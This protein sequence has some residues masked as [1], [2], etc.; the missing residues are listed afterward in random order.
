MR[1]YS[2]HQKARLS[3]AAAIDQLRHLL[4]RSADGAV[5]YRL[6]LSELEDRVL[7]SASPAAVMVES[8]PAIELAETAS[9][10]VNGSNSLIQTA[11]VT[12]DATQAAPESGSSLE[13]NSQFLELDGTT[14]SSSSDSGQGSDTISQ[15]SSRTAEQ[16][17]TEVVFIDE[18][19]QNFEQLVADL[20]AQR[21]AGRAVDF[22][23]LD[24]QQDGIDQISE[25]LQRYS[26]LD[27]IHFVSHGTT[28][29]VKLGATWLRIGSLDGYAGTIAGWGSAFGTDG[30]LLIYGCDL[31]AD[32][33][34]Q[35]LV[36]SI[37]ALTGADVAAST[38]DTGSALFGGDWELEY[39]IGT[40]EADVAFTEQLQTEWDGLLAAPT[41]VSSGEFRING[42]TTD[43]QL[44]IAEDRGS[45]Q[46]VS[47][48]ADGSYVVV[49]SSLN[50]DGSGQGVYARR[51][52][53]AGAAL[54]TEFRVNQT[55]TNDQQWARVASAVDGSFVVTWTSNQ[56]A[57]G[58]DVYFRRFAAN[59]TALTAEARANTTLSGTQNNSVVG[60]N[61]TSGEFI[62]AWQG[63]GS[64]TGEIDGAGV[65]AQ[66][67]SNSGAA[68]GGEFRVN[69]N[70]ANTQYDVAISVN[71]NGSF[72]VAWDDSA[73]TH[74]QRFGNTGN[75]LGG[76]VTV[77]GSVSAGNAAVA[78][79]SDG[80]LIVTWRASVLDQGVYLR[81]YDASGTPL[82]PAFIANT[83]IIGSQTNPSIAMDSS[84]NFIIVWEG[85]GTGDNSGVFARR[86][87]ANSTAQGT[88]FRI[89]QT[90]TGTQQYA[91][92]AMADLDNYVVVW[93]GNG[94]QTGQVDSSG[95]FARQYGTGTVPT[96]ELWFTTGGNGA[97][98]GSTWT[99]AEVLQFG[100][101]GDTFDVNAGT[102]SGTISKLPG[103]VA[104]Y[105]IRAMHYVEST[106][107]LGTTGT[108][109][110]VL[111]GDLILTLDPGKD[112]T[113][114]AGGVAVD[115]MDIVVFRPTV[116][117]DYSSGTYSMLIDGDAA[118][119]DSGVHDAIKAYNVHAISLVEKDTLVGGTVLTKGTFLVAHSDKSLHHNIYTFNVVGTGV[120]AATE[121]TPVNL[122]LSGQSLGLDGQPSDPWKIQGLHLLQQPTQFNGTTL[123]SGTLLVTVEGADIYGGQAQ[124]EFDIVALTVTKT[125]QDAV[126]GTVASGQLFFDGS[127]IAINTPTDELLNGFTIISSSFAGAESNLAPT[128]N[129]GGAYVTTEGSAVNLIGSAS[130]DPD[131]DPLTYAWDLDND[132]YFGEVGEPTTVSP[133]VSWATLQ[134][135]GINDDTGGPYTIALRVDDG[136]GGVHTAT[137]TVIVNNAAP[138]LSTTGSG[139][140]TAGSSYTLNLSASDPGADTISSW[141]INWGDGSIETIAGN[142]TSATH[143]YNAA[144]FTYNILASA[145]DE[146][147][148]YLQNELLV[149][150][151]KNDRVLRYGPDAGFLQAFAT[152]DGSDYPVDTIIGPDGKL[153]VSG[154]NSDN[155]LRYDAM[156]GAFIDAFVPA[157]SGGLDSAAG[158][159]FGP[160]GHLY[161]ASRLTSEVLRFN[162]S[163]GVF[164]DAFVTAG[165]GGLDEVEGL[166]F[167]PDGDLYVTDYKNNAV[168]KYDGT[169]GAFDSVFV[170][171]GSGGL[172]K[173]ED[174]TF[175]PDGNLYVADDSGSSV[176]RYDGTTGTFINTFVASGSGGLT[177]ATGV[178][179]GPDGNLYV[180]SWG[181]DSVLRYDGIT[182]AFIDAYISSGSGGLDE[183]DYFTFIPE[184]QVSVTAIP[185]SSPT[186]DAG[187]PYIV[188]EGTTVSLDGTASSDSDGMLTLYEWDLN[189]DGVTFNSTTTGS[190]PVFNAATIDGPGSRA[191]ALRVTDNQGAVSSLSTTTVT[192]NN[193]APTATPDSGAGFTTDENTS[194]TTNSVLANDSDVP[195]DTLSVTGLGTAGTVGLVINNGDGTFSYNPNGQFESLAVGQQ[196]T[197]SFSYTVSDGDGG[198]SLATVTV[199]INGAN[200]VPVVTP[201]QTFNISESATNGTSLG[202]VAATD[203]DAG[204]T[205]SN[206]QITGGNAA[207]VFGI[208][209]STGA[210]TVVDRSNLNFESNTSYVL[211]VT[212]RDGVNTSSVE[213]IAISVLD[214]NDETPVITPGQTFNVSESAANGTPLGNVAATDADAGTTLSNWQI[215]GGNAAGVFGINASTGQLTVADNS[216][217]NFEILSTYTL[218]VRTQDGAG[219]TGSGIVFV[220][221]SNTNETPTTSGLSDVVVNEDSADVLI[222]L[223][224]AFSDPET[225]SPGLSYSITSNSNPAIFSGTPI[226]GGNLILKFAANANGN[227]TVTVS[228]TDPQGLFATASFTVTVLPVADA[229]ISNADSYL[230]TSDRLTVP[231]GAGV[232]ANDSDPDGDPLTALL[233]TGPTHGSL[234]L[235]SNGG[236]SFIPDAD[237]RGIDTFVYQP[238]DGASTGL[239]RTVILNVIRVIA[240]PPAPSVDTSQVVETLTSEVTAESE[241]LTVSVNAPVAVTE[242]V[243]PTSAIDDSTTATTS[244]NAD[245]DE[246]TEEELAAGFVADV[247]VS[248]FFSVDSDRLELRDATSVRIFTEE[249][250]R[251]V[252]VSTESENNFR[253]SLRFDGEDLSYLVGAEFIQELEQVEDGFE[254]DGAVPE[255]ATGTAVATTASL[256]VGYIMWMLRGGYVL[257]SVL[258]T[259][260]VWQNIDPLPVL[261][262]LEAVDDD[263]DE[264]LET[265]ID[266]A[267]D[268]ADHSENQVADEAAADA[269]LKDELV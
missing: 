180:G 245:S 196:T 30:D 190:T 247:T 195:G 172:N 146:D 55:T 252:T 26:N 52:D 201:G 68:L 150:S 132:G 175:G 248:D 22:F 221:V 18:A 183:T 130:S 137:T 73:G 122:L 70:T 199:T 44:T 82:A 214:Q 116:T 7:L 246:E 206:W 93:S 228:A 161:V 244:S 231:P 99:D 106:V 35:M 120:G 43:Q 147:G 10:L 77:D 36:D 191:V 217:L 230:V 207:G 40:V 227:A 97:G 250:D 84:G 45:Q 1:L 129:A 165:S 185:N 255:W 135:F 80:S 168:Y 20:Q 209:A 235:L 105:D 107:T 154:W 170:S 4:A 259:M 265:M 202:N 193:V 123:L 264:S 41:L 159:A 119:L 118:D 131:S 225:P 188:N 114:N 16:I 33:R 266:R 242:Y 212:V 112:T 88:E 232:L 167:G 15:A 145:T 3:A 39:S 67:F 85:E 63:N 171:A 9:P 60:M 69:A 189:Y 186:A 224:T 50:Q 215:T 65:F 155:V 182:G 81:R 249:F 51:F 153:Y 152:S 254:F 47:L 177:F 267:S 219:N 269:A 200:D 142:P 6:D 138:V 243:N 187:G 83:T 233:I 251:P 117:G 78:M 62:I 5:T 72:V 144:G 151:G 160:D 133:T 211:S 90:T 94:N 42:T 239:P 204:T 61:S 31:A 21:D 92:L 115:R 23:V 48:A 203:A 71:T 53:A 256:S 98:G 121:T 208:N 110:T 87:L 260:P 59:G 66:R 218:N 86:Y 100:D 13:T 236:F 96:A 223:K 37:A 127:D 8:A 166:I 181:T 163:T 179:F 34:G 140:V 103:F 268:E 128:A 108:Q 29:A 192:I 38:D 164:I 24:S 157:G 139:T 124:D 220:N 75:E 263:D 194:F 229:P 198:S 56:G 64:Q 136:K 91:S 184:H 11:A 238:F 25:T 149:A 213:T 234:V 143:T 237:F 28:G 79:H 89:N 95:V 173:P 158:L 109:F 216:T 58:E 102:T 74:I 241:A 253:N 111:K 261:A 222:N 148:T 49:W 101:A 240:L 14:D 57:S 27:A 141:T 156:T 46:A 104:P 169:T 258:S 76:Q 205:F 32:S 197:D 125:E 257:A 126:P 174:L 178:G 176:R 134:S 54:T 226:I 2:L 12:T 17:A 19:A 210:L 113:G 262:A 162:G